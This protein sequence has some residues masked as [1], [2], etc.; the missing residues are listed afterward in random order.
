MFGGLANNPIIIGTWGLYAWSREE[1]TKVLRH[2]YE[3]GFRRFDTAAVYGGGNA[4]LDISTLPR[5]IEIHTK[6]PSMTKNKKV[7]FKEAYPIKYVNATLRDI[8][9]RLGTHQINVLYL[10]NWDVNWNRSKN[11]GEIT[12][13]CK[14]RSK[15][16]GISLP[17]DYNL[18][19]EEPSID[20]ISEY[21]DVVQLPY[22]ASA[23]KN[24]SLIRRLLDRGLTINLRSVLVHGLLIKNDEELEKGNP[25]LLRYS[26]NERRQLRG[27]TEKQNIR[28]RVK[29]CIDSALSVG[30]V[31]VIL[32]VTKSEHINDLKNG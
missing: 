14:D 4:E 10:H 17:S 11:I 31:G 7:T 21:F 24:G 23:N 1:P 26:N 27:D 19:M 28:E 15:K 25:S 5:D 9:N 20:L 30:P 18:F 2:A 8:R 32:G 22:C 29:Y 12:R 16:I 6:I 13:I 3:S